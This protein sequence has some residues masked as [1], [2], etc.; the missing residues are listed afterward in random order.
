MHFVLY[1]GTNIIGYAHLQL[2]SQQRAAM[3]IIAIDEEKRN[4]QYGSQFL[5]LCEKWIKSQGYKCCIL[6]PL[7][8]L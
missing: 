3:R 4:H 1:E 6:N 5:Q 8:R 7:P 2:W